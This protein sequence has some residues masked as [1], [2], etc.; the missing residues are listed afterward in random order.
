MPIKTIQYHEFELKKPK[1]FPDNLFQELCKHGHVLDARVEDDQPHEIRDALR[2]L[3]YHPRDSKPWRLAAV[4]PAV[5]GHGPMQ[6]SSFRHLVGERGFRSCPEVI[7]A[8]LCLQWDKQ[9]DLP[10]NHGYTTLMQPIVL[11]GRSYWQPG[12]GARMV[13]FEVGFHREKPYLAIGHRGSEGYGFA[14]TGIDEDEW[15]IVER[16]E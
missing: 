4:S 11:G 2:G 3:H 5:F 10:S 12:H 7:A 13:M 14:Y 8:C 16:K 1:K 9:L 15:V 6:I